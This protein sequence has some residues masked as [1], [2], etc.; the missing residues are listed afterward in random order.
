MQPQSA[1]GVDERD[2]LIAFGVLVAMLLIAG[3]IAWRTWRT[4]APPMPSNGRM[5]RALLEVLPRAMSGRVVELGSGWGGLAWRLARLYPAVAV[6]GVECSELPWLVSWL[7]LKLTWRRPKHLQ[8]LYGDFFAQD[9]TDA[10]LVVCYLNPET[11]SRLR[12]KLMAELRPGAYVACIG[13]ALPE[14][15]PMAVRHLDDWMQ[16]K[17]YL[18]QMEGE[19]PKP[20]NYAV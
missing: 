3:W 20:L 5:R 10:Q 4:G 16:T 9:L 14:I 13:F 7:R 1:A 19:E 2:I 12:P 17:I 8:F 18:Y 15:P 6:V 11:M